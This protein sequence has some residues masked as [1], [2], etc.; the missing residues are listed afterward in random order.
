MILSR[1]WISLVTLKLLRLSLLFIGL[2][3]FYNSTLVVSH[4]NNWLCICDNY[5]KIRLIDANR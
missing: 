1:K 4:S 5:C 3:F 2:G